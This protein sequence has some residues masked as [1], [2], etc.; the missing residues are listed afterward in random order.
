MDWRELTPEV[1]AEFLDWVIS[2]QEQRQEAGRLK[3][4]DIFVGDP[5]LHAMEEIFDAQFYIWQELRRRSY[6]GEG[7][8]GH[9]D[10]AMDGVTYDPNE[11]HVDGDSLDRVMGGVGGVDS[12]LGVVLSDTL[13]TV[14][15][16]KGRI[17]F[18]LQPSENLPHGAKIKAYSMGTV[19]DGVP[20]VRI[21]I[22]PGHA[23]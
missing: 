19:V 20:Y 2:M 12:E 4:G 1:R 16:T 13:R 14:I 17:E 5:V 6:M 18:D 10:R 15:V 22:L 8:G 7:Q 3:H 23:S 11:G 9:M 21:D